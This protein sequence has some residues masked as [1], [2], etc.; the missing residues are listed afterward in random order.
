MGFS[1]SSGIVQVYL[2]GS[3]DI[4]VAQDELVNSGRVKGGEGLNINY[5]RNIGDHKLSWSPPF[6]YD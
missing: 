3:K 1:N 5:I 2:V 4:L 6:L